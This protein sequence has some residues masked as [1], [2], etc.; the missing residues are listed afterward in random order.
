MGWKTHFDSRYF[1]PLIHLN[2]TPDIG[3]HAHARLPSSL[4]QNDGT[5][6]HVASNP[7]ITTRF[8]NNFARVPKYHSKSLLTHF[9][10]LSS[11]NHLCGV[12]IDCQERSRVF[13][14]IQARSTLTEK[15]SINLGSSTHRA[16]LT[17]GRRHHFVLHFLPVGGPFLTNA[18]RLSRL[19]NV[20][21]LYDGY[22]AIG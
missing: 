4:L 8:G 14:E 7:R 18:H 9:V 3:Q 12:A 20:R 11:N 10:S 21:S 17:L 13:L 6:N 19:V 16:G 5:S 2:H 15:F 22:R 1:V